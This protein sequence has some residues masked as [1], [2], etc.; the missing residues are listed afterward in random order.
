M[1]TITLDND[2]D[3]NIL[4]IWGES[5]SIQAPAP[6]LSAGN[7]DFG[8]DFPNVAKPVSYEAQGPLLVECFFHRNH[9]D[10]S[11]FKW[12]GPDP[13]SIS[14]LAR[15]LHLNVSILSFRGD[16][17]DRIPTCTI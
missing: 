8:L 14:T 7:E 13:L 10:Q 12:T 9:E 4:A 16:V 17:L 2:F 3:L 5:S 1:L 11:G 15:P 6:C